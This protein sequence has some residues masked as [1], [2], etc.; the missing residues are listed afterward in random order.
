ML[1]LLFCLISLSLVG[2]AAWFLAPAAPL[3]DLVVA[4]ERK[5]AGLAA[6]T[7]L[8][9]GHT[10]AYLE[11]GPTTDAAPILLVHG[12]SGEKDNWT[13]IARFLT[14]RHRVIAIDLPGFGDSA[15]WPG[16][17][18]GLQ[19]QVA[20]LAAIVDALGL[21]KLHLGGNSMGARVIALYAAAHPD[22]VRSL[23]LPGP[24]GILSAMPSDLLRH[25]QAGGDNPLFIRSMT[26][27]PVYLSWLM[28]HPPSI[29]APVGR[30][31]A[32]RALGKADFHRSVFDAFA[33]ET[34]SLELSVSGMTVPTRIVWGEHDR[35]WH[36]SG[37]ALLADH[38]TRASLL[39][40]PCG[41]LPMIE[42]PEAVATD[43]L[44]FL[45]SLSTS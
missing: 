36:V 4:V 34:A 10:I 37:A 13:R 28:M 15:R 6:K 5:R 25:L 43:Y 11:G 44:A 38:L 35:I 1:I 2:A 29:P 17:D 7:I 26:D 18:I 3:R 41:H 27:Y 39:L 23:W 42:M 22:R 8:V 32:E 30:A 21:R 31:L 20:A 24:S 14:P 9:Q 19:G 33:R 12:S 40:L 16:H 45:S